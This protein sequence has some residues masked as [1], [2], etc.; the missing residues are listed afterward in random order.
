MS[1]AVVVGVRTLTRVSVD[2]MNG[3]PVD[4]QK[5]GNIVRDL[6]SGQ[7]QKQSICSVPH[8]FLSLHL[9]LP[10][11]PHFLLPHFLFPGSHPCFVQL[12]LSKISAPPPFGSHNFFFLLCVSVLACNG[13]IVLPTARIITEVRLGTYESKSANRA[14]LVLR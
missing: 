10:S 4:L 13:S 5:G 14:M 6:T 1:W 11:S 12:F 9:L 3:L 7:K 8:I 2:N